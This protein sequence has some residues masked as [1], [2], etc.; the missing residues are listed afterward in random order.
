MTRTPRRTNYNYFGQPQK[1]RLDPFPILIGAFFA[2][3][4]IG[5]LSLGFIWTGVTNTLSCTVN[6][7]T[8]TNTD[9][10]TDYRVYTDECGVLQ[11]QDELFLWKFDAADRYNA[12]KVGNSYEFDTVGWRAPFFSLFPSIVEVR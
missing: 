5:T 6:D 7:K 3:I 10:G 4:I 12:V 2:L 1:R 11:I 9:S 8:A